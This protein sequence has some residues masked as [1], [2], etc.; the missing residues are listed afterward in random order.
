MLYPR[1]KN[2]GELNWNRYW[3]L[4]AFLLPAGNFV[5][6]YRLQF[7]S[8][9]RPV[10]YVPMIILKHVDKHQNKVY[11]EVNV[12]LNENANHNKVIVVIASGI[13]I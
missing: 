9:I 12:H 3:S 5:R 10:I 7:S 11:G 2:T 8:S 6:L 13:H 1:L 4:D